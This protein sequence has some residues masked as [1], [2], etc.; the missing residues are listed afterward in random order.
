MFSFFCPWP[1]S[2]CP[3]SAAPTMPFISRLRFA[4]AEQIVQYVL[5]VVPRNY[6]IDC[7]N[8]AYLAD[9]CSPFGTTVE[10]G[11]IMR[12][13]IRRY[14]PIMAAM[15]GCVWGSQNHGNPGRINGAEPLCKAA[16]GQRIS[17]GCSPGD[18]RPCELPSGT[19]SASHSTGSR[20][21][22]WASSARSGLSAAVIRRGARRWRGWWSPGR[23][24]TDVRVVVLF[25][26]F[27]ADFQVGAAAN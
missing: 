14:T 25:L 8:Q 18:S 7:G 27:T 17:I 1:V 5:W 22:R 23:R 26:F 15:V 20:W 3:R 2:E 19:F 16:N 6:R 24:R 12:E 13:I 9:V 11:K 10:F 4:T 21:P